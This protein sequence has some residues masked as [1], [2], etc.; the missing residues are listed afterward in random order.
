MP[1]PLKSKMTTTIVT[2]S[3]FISGCVYYPKK[4]EY[5]DAECDI[6]FKMLV[7]ET[8]EMKD[9]CLRQKS[10]DPNGN[11]CLMAVI[12]TTALS[13]IISGSLVVVGNTVYWLEKEAMCIAK[14]M[15]K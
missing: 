15:P 1:A 7:L 12:G 2:L 3:L 8:D 6:K 4:I 10:G 5:Y 14:T 13:A 11:L 9:T